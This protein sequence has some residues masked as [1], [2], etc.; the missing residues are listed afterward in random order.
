MEVEKESLMKLK[1]L[2]AQLINV[3]EKVDKE[4]TQGDV[5][6]FNLR[7]IALEKIEAAQQNSNTSKNSEATTVTDKKPPIKCE[8]EDCDT[9][10][11]LDLELNPKMNQ[12]LDEEFDSD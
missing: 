5:E 6:W 10:F 1:K 11:L 12:K 9:D 8:F 3:I 2:E 4:I 7:S